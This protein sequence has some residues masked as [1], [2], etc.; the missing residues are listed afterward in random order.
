[1]L[2]VGVPG[3]LRGGCQHRHGRVGTA[4]KTVEGQVKT[5]E[6]TALCAPSGSQRT[7]Q[8]SLFV[9]DLHRPL[10]HPPG[11][12]QQDLGASGQEV[13]EEMLVGGQPREPRL[14]AVEAEALSQP[15]PR[16]SPP[17]LGVPQCGGP[18]SD[19]ERRKKF[20]AA[21]HDDLVQVGH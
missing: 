13:D 3:P 11:L 7:G 10:A 12:E 8:V 2:I 9:G 4:Q 16:F 18:V 1:M 5:G 21:E 17:G 15:L 6:I 19:L 14:H 20:A